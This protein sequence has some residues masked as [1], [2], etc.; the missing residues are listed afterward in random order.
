L[1]DSKLKLGSG[2]SFSIVPVAVVSTNVAFTASL[3]M[4]EKVSSASFSRSLLT[5]TVMFCVSVPPVKV[6]VP[7]VAV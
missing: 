5:V 3:R 2:S 6:S 4:I 1:F 7:L